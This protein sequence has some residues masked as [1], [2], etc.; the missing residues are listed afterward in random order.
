MTTRARIAVPLIIAMLLSGLVALLVTKTAS[1]AAAAPVTDFNPGLIISDAAMYDSTSMTAGEVQT[2][3]SSKGASCSAASGY[4]CIKNY[5]ETTPSRGADVLCTG[6]YVGASNE[7]AAAIIAKVSVACGINPQVLLVTLQKEQ[8]LI[9]ATAGKSAAT[10]S[11]ALGFGCPDNVG[12]WCDP[13]YAGFANQVYSAAK[14]LK[15]YAANPT[16]YS[17]RAGRTNTVLWHPNTTCGSS[18]VFIQNQATASLYNYTPYRPNAAAL[19][20]GYGSGDACSSYGNRNFHLY[21]SSWFGSAVQRAPIGVIDSVSATPGNASIRVRGWALDPDTNTSIN[22]HIYVD[23]KVVSSALA[24]ASRPDVAAVHGRGPAHGFDKSITA[25]AGAH[26][27]CVY[28]IDSTRGPNSFLGCS[29]VSVSNQA[30]KGVI[31]GVTAAP[32]AAKIRGWALDPDAST[33]ISVHVYV[34]GKMSRSIVADTTR[35]DVGRIH[36]LGDNHGFDALIPMSDGSHTL[37]I[38]AIDSSSGS[39]PLLGCR[40]V[41]VTNAAPIGSFDTLTS[42]APGS[43]RIRGWAFDRDTAD[44]IS[45]HVYVDGKVSKA[46]TANAPRPD[47]AQ[48]YSVAATHGFDATLPAV[49]GSHTVCIYAI[50]S[51]GGSNPML[52]CRTVT[53]ENSVTTGAVDTVVAA[54]SVTGG[55][56]KAA[57]GATV[58][59]TGWAWDFDTDAHVAV[60]LLLDQV[61]A[62]SGTAS[63]RRTD[64]TPTSRTDVGF[65]LTTTAAPGSHEVCIRATDPTTSAR[66]DLGCRSVDV[67]NTAARGVIDE[68][69]GSNGTIRVRGWTLDPDTTSPISVHVYLNGVVATSLLA[70]GDRPDVDAAFG[71]GRMRG[72][73]TSIPAQPGTH[74]VCVYSIGWPA[75]SGNPLI[76][77]QIVT[78]P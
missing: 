14:Q 59:A 54:P 39:N 40:V 10:Y 48:A 74:T 23:G 5:A 75:G 41:R 6:A 32:G 38:Y 49:A 4:T 2:F 65:T 26:A 11:R 15:R 17:Y 60:D 69:S 22:V 42:S 30:P 53:V 8:G 21:F 76:G 64:V 73:S 47:V 78:V 72:F 62:A 28:A 24:D 20:A 33:A 44:S 66:V 18:Q 77:C 71:A 25:S 34:D 35:A 58:R 3:L 31:D 1:T 45:V 9:T 56:G 46:V 27:V 12:G 55:G 7:T 68:A 13:S 50:D 67:P 70:N 36:G 61:V 29:T 43:I 19:A 52:G 51:S 57:I 63:A 16:N 37:C